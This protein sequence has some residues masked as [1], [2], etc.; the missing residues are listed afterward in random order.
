[1]TTEEL[2][3]KEEE[4]NL[5]VK[6]FLDDHKKFLAKIQFEIYLLAVRSIQNWVE[7]GRV[8]PG[9]AQVGFMF[10]MDKNREVAVGREDN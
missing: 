6:D 9:T 5:I 1:M 4:S 3:K 8:L 10:L 2:R 7:R